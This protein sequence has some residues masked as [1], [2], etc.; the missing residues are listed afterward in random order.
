MSWH[1][2]Q[3][4][5]AEYLADICSDGERSVQLSGSPTPL[6]YL[7]LDRMKAFSRLSRYGMTF[8]PLTDDLGAALLTWYLEA[9]LAKTS[10]QPEREPALP[11]SAAVC[12]RT[13]HGSLAKYDHDTRSWKTRQFSF[14][15]D[16]MW[17]SGIWP[18]W[19]MMRNGECSAR[20]ILD[21]I[22]AARASFSWPTPTKWEGKYVTSPSPGDH[23]HGIGW[24][25]WHEYGKRPTPEIYDEA[26]NFPLGWT[27]LNALGMLKF[28]QWCA[29]HGIPLMNASTT[30]EHG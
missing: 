27:Q 13:W 1:F 17:F 24:K 25:C 18:R 26:M 8:K 4:L 15:G 6:L 29:S 14:Q 19:G 9:S 21:W 22:T 28:Q 3:A 5:V 11:E 20:T 12:G 23:Y 16:L 10:A 2:S 30:A 7:P